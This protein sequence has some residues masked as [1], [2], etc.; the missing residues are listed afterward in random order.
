MGI[1]SSVGIQLLEQARMA[2][3]N[4]YAPFSGFSVGAALLTIDGQVFLGCNVENSSYGLTICAERTAAVSAIACGA[5]N[6]Q[7]IAVVSPTSVPPCGACLQFLSEFS[8]SLE[9]WIAALDVSKPYRVCSISDLLP[10][11]M[12]LDISP[13]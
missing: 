10:A 7:A 6:W 8:Q 5:R 4:A 13:Q 11:A 2:A 1:D 9:I 12:R 3:K